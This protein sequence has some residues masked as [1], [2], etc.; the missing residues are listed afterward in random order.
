MPSI[1]YLCCTFRNQ[2]LTLRT[3]QS[4]CTGLQKPDE[5]HAEACFERGKV[6]EKGVA[7][8]KDMDRALKY[9][10]KAAEQGHKEAKKHVKA[11]TSAISKMS[12]K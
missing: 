7:L 4:I 10:Q 2:I 5:S 12:K 9:M 11:L 8:P 3:L 6:F 1:G